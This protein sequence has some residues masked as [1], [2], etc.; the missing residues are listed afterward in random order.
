MTCLSLFL[1]YGTRY[2]LISCIHHIIDVPQPSMVVRPGQSVC[3][4]FNHPEEF[5]YVEHADWTKK[6]QYHVYSSFY[7][8]Y[9]ILPIFSGTLS[10]IYGAKYLL[11][12][13]VLAC[14]FITACQPLISST[15]LWYWAALL[16][17]LLGIMQGIA[18]PAI[19]SLLSQWL[20]KNHQLLLIT[21]GYSG[22][23]LGATLC[24]SLC[25]IFADMT[26]NWTVVFYFW[27]G[28]IAVWYVM[29]M[30]LIHSSPA[31]HPWVNPE[32]Q[33]TMAEEIGVDMPKSIPWKAIFTN[34]GVWG[35]V[36]GQLA[37]TCLIV[38]I[39]IH[40]PEFLL[41][42]LSVSR[43]N[44]GYIFLG[45]FICQWISTIVCGCIADIIVEKT[46]FPHIHVRYICI[47]VGNLVP[48]CIL[49]FSTNI[50]CKKIFILCLVISSVILRGTTISAL[51]PNILDVTR[52]YSGVVKGIN[53]TVPAMVGIILPQIVRVL[54]RK[55]TLEAWRRVFWITAG[56]CS[57]MTCFYLIF[58][59][60]DRAHWDV[61]NQD[62]PD[63]E[64]KQV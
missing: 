41:F 18:V 19:V 45:T 50:G 39:N 53:C 49:A 43:I 46:D 47:I 36:C 27:A 22:G 16:Q 1:L 2:A 31:V 6:Q 59:K 42:V 24:A 4:G 26:D 10:D 34:T 44:T 38:L 5:T 61:I 17:C 54:C 40:L 29:F 63:E 23:C 30:L 57:S 14:A 35:I 55:N 11:S 37:D 3:H 13:S 62:I 56:F 21:Y 52:H 7:V 33:S 15:K 60:K 9:A 51:T 20:P 8:G 64:V 28:A 48:G 58:S 32:E 25:M 12:T